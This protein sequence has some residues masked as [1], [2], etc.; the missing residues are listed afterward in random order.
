[1]GSM[2]TLSAFD[3]EFWNLLFA[4]VYDVSALGSNRCHTYYLCRMRH[5]EFLKVLSVFV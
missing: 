4:K 3:A 2:I 1:M 5:S